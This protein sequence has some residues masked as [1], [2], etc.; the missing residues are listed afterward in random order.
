MLQIVSAFGLVNLAT[1]LFL[2]R[3]NQ[4]IVWLS[5]TPFLVLLIPCISIPFA[6][7]LSQHGDVINIITFQRLLF[8]IPPGLVLTL[9]GSRLL[10]TPIPDILPTALL[11]ASLAGIFCL[12]A[13][14]P[15]YNR[16]WHSLTHIPADLQMT[17][18]LAIAQ[19]P[20]ITFPNPPK[21]ITTYQTGA[22][23]QAS[24]VPK[25]IYAYRMIGW[26]AVDF[27]A[28]AIA[29]VAAV[30]NRGALVY[31][32]SF[33]NLSANTSLA[34][35]LSTHWSPQEVAIDLSAGA[36]LNV[37]AINAGAVKI[38]ISNDTLFELRKTTSESR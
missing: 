17:S 8:A 16:T 7:A 14:G 11:A 13:K 31:I 26:A 5:I 27:A 21:F 33:H 6:I 30:E 4:V 28:N 20:Q 24:G 37:A 2:L 12:P 3:R 38:P 35:L 22:V 1:A 19:S 18:I 32:P 36:E 34:G 10:K 29:A 15:Q 25:T 23:L 9:M